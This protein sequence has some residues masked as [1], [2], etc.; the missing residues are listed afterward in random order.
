MIYAY[1]LYIFGVERH[2]PSSVCA[3]SSC[4]ASC[5]IASSRPDACFGFRKSQR[6]SIY[7]SIYIYIYIYLYLHLSI[8]IYLS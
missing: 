8:S 7:L 5:R 4:E 3:S 2:R 1:N 6:L